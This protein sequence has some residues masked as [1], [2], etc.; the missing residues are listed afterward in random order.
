MYHPMVQARTVLSRAKTYDKSDGMRLS[1]RL[2]G[3]LD[4]AGSLVGAV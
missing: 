2:S 4:S 3:A 1:S